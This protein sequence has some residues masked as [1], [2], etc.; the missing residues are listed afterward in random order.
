MP[1]KPP[2]PLP[3][4]PT[5]HRTKAR[6]S[7]DWRSLTS[8]IEAMAAKGL[9]VEQIVESLGCATSTFY[10]NR[11]KYPEIEESFKKG[12]AGGIKDIANALFEKA[13]AGDTVA[14]I[15][16]LKSRGGWSDKVS[17]QELK[18]AKEE[19]ARF[20]E[21]FRLI[22]SITGESTELLEAKQQI[23]SMLDTLLL[24]RGKPALMKSIEEGT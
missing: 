21:T 15:F 10:E 5:D 1:R 8:N 17:E 12:R 22:L 20:Y 2:E 23:V 18:N 16:Y 14:M 24:E 6:P 4:P 9:T 7:I 13:I 3:T 11:K 19:L